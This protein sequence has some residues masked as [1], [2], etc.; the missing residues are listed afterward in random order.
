MIGNMRVRGMAGTASWGVIAAATLMGA[1]AFAQQSS[2]AASTPSATSDPT[3]G[4][5][6]VTGT[7]ESLRSAIARKKN[8]GT[9]VDSIVA[10]DIASFPDKNVGEALSRITGVQ[11]SRE[12]GEGNQISIRG[13]E[14]D[15]NRIEINGVSQQSALGGRTG[16]F[17][18]LQVELVKS[19]D[20]YKGYTVDLTEGGIGGTVS[21][22]TRRPLDLKDPIFSI[23]GEAQRLN[24][25]KK[26]QPRFNLLAGRSDLLDGRLGVILNVTHNQVDTRGDSVSNTNWNRI[27]DFD[28]T[29]QKTVVN[30]LYANFATYA[31]CGGTTGNTATVATANRLACETQFF[32]WAPQSVR[33]RTLDR[34]DN[35]TSIDGQLQFEVANNFSV[36]GQ[37]QLN[38]RNQTLRDVNYS[39]D[40]GVYQRYNF[41]AA[42]AA[43]AAGGTSRPQI[44][45]GTT[46]VEDQVVTSIITQRN[47]LNISATAVP[48]FNG[49]NGIV[50]V[51]RRDFDYNEQSKYYQ[52]GFKWDIGPL[53]FIGLGSRSSAKNTNNTNNISISTGVGG[54]SIDRRNEAGLPVIT[55]PESFDPA[56]AADYGNFSRTGANGQPLVQAGPSIQYRPSRS[57]AKE[58][59][60]KLDA[61]YDT[62]WAFLKKIEVGGQYRKQRLDLFQAGGARLLTPAVVAVPAAGIVGVPAVFQTNNNVTTNSVIGPVPATGPALDTVYF[63][64]EQYQ[65]F[66]SGN[67]GVTGGAP[68]FTG[69]PQA[70]GS[71]DRLAIPLFEPASLSQFFDLSRFNQNTLLFADGL[72]QIPSYIINETIKS[73]Y[74]KINFEQEIFGMT[75]TGNAGYRYTH[76]RNAS[77]SV[78]TRRENRIRPGT[79]VNGIAPVL[80]TVTTG[81]QAVSID[82]SYD[83]WLPAVNLNLEALSNLFIRATYA[84]NLARPRPIDLSPAINCLI[85]AA[86][87]I[88]GD[89][90]CTAGNPRLQPYRADQY[91]LNVAWYPN[92]DT[93]ISVGYYY[94]DVTSFVLPAQTLNGV[95]LF[96]DGILYTVRQ[97]TNGFGAKL[98]GIEASVQT[99]FTFLPAPFDGFGASGNMT[100]ARA[101]NQ[102][103]TNLATN[104]PLSGFP[105]LSKYTYNASMFYDKDWLNARVSV[106]K[107]TGWL[108]FATSA[109]NGNNPLYRGG[110]TY[111]DAKVLFRLTPMFSFWVEGLNLTKEIRRDLI[112]AARVV[113]YTD[114]GQR[115]FVGAQLK[116]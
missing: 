80:E 4:D 63:T 85:D 38:Y 43:N 41:D 14:P 58:D 111:V 75:L 55:F 5:I 11:L 24:L 10:D 59:Q 74:F 35:R 100:Y 66:L 68:L 26:W 78:N 109:I 51:N 31:S 39:V 84:K 46:T 53:N 19:I 76:T 12:F 3:D 13:V 93:L 112:D 45:A 21:V 65:Q 33:Y 17:R 94:K 23:K 8:A 54:I 70:E 42:L 57:T 52:T 113:E 69:I 67:T 99:A 7:R 15:L 114:N 83:D 28:R 34:S 101:L 48:T 47:G 82:N 97:P 37:A 104:E 25:T 44:T 91:D 40:L 110:E 36:W 77:T 61:D 115:I 96:G 30:P 1:P 16:D 2:V 81:V 71:P 95:D 56:N 106:N 6:L 32:D 79:G 88:A 87:T 27:A 20:V 86:N 9:V 62:G 90:T 105:G 49:A 92:R 103:L 72:P 22:E 64:R 102:S 98:D 29:D 89:D 116:F 73:A 18:E 108:A 60:L 107:R 50:G